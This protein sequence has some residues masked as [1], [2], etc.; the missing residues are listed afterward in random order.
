MRNSLLIFISFSAVTLLIFFTRNV[1]LYWY[2]YSIPVFIAAFTYDVYG[3]VIVGLLSLFFVAPWLYDYYAS[4]KIPF[5]L[6][7]VIGEVALGMA[8]LL[9][10]G[11]VFGVLSRKQKDQQKTLET[12]SK[13][14]RLTGLSNY[15]YFIDRLANEVKRA[16]RYETSFSLFMLDID[17]FKDFNDTF[18]HEK[19]NLVL[20]KVAKIINRWVREVDMAARYGG[21]EFAV[22]LPNIDTK[23][24]TEV[25][26][27]IRKE[28]AKAGFEGDPVEP[29][30]KKTVSIGVATFP[31]D[32]KSDTELIVNADEALYKAKESGRDKVCVYLY[33]CKTAESEKKKAGA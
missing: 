31:Q 22:V 23:E 5:S 10:I 33:D 30:V 11:A 29:K 3:G 13:H 1:V 18:G 4:G 24:A 26:E 20:T 19:G 7:E 15:S 2:F 27:R 14:D 9:T 28:V 6:L 16:E 32:A 8:L 25:A 17:D 21:E 12:L